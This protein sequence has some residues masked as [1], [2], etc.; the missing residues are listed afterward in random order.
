MRNFSELTYLDQSKIN[1]LL[2]GEKRRK[3]RG[4]GRRRGK[5]KSRGQT[6]REMSKRRTNRTQKLL[7]GLLTTAKKRQ[8]LF[9]PRKQNQQRQ[10]AS[11]SR[12]T[13]SPTAQPRKKRPRVKKNQAS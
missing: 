13:R 8:N 3:G 12:R 2:A 10:Q 7:T 5:Q 4:R 11:T 9:F 1:L 6:W